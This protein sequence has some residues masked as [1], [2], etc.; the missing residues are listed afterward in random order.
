MVA[1]GGVGL[2]GVL[3]APPGP[4]QHAVRVALICLDNNPEP[5]LHRAATSSSHEPR[6]SM[7]KL[8]HRRIQPLH[9]QVL[10]EG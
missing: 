8:G 10:G 6:N 2:A 5:I 9:L 3:E 4:P 7:G 1:G